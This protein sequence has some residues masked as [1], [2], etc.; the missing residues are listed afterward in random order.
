VI[1]RVVSLSAYVLARRTEE[2]ADTLGAMA[3]R[4]EEGAGHLERAQAI[5]EMMRA[6]LQESAYHVARAEAL[7]ARS[8]EITAGNASVGGRTK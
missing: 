5:I 2:L 6:R 4:M 7:R 1:G 3:R 8:R